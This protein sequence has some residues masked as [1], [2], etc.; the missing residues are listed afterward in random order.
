MKLK[1]EFFK[2]LQEKGLDTNNFSFGE[3]IAWL[4]QEWHDNRHYK[5]YCINMKKDLLLNPIYVTLITKHADLGR[6]WTH[7]SMI[8]MEKIRDCLDIIDEYCR[9]DVK[10]ENSSY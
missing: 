2:Y 5:D 3:Y 6:L 1:E 10:N 9:K 8:K 7:E 4:E